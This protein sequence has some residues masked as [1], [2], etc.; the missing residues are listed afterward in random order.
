MLAKK[1]FTLILCLGVLAP[2][3]AA[4]SYKDLSH[5]YNL[6]F[7][8]FLRKK[9]VKLPKK[10]TVEV[11]LKDGTSVKGTFEGFS[12]Y[13]DGFWILPLGKRGLFAD[14]AYDISEIQDVRIIILRSI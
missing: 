13:D 3:Y 7:Q 6:V 4:E 10:A 1:L 5:E 2:V 12:K 9:I 14:D 8:D 11:F